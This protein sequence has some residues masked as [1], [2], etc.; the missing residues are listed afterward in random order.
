MTRR[1]R[2]VILGALG[3]VGG[4]LCRAFAEEY[5][6]VAVDARRRRDRRVIRGDMRRLRDAERV[7]DGAD[8]VVDLVTAPWQGPFETVH[9]NNIPATW[10]AFEAARRHGVARVVYASSNHVTG[11][12]ERDAPYCRIVAGDYEGL[13]PADF[14]KITTSMPIR[15]DSPY[16]VGKAFG[17]AT[18]RFYADAH[19]VPAMCLRI[20]SLNAADRP[21]SARH[22]A[23]LLTHADLTR[24]V[25]CC[26]EAP[27]S[28]DFATF[29]GVSANRWRI[30]DIDDA[31]DLIGYEPHDDAESWRSDQDS[32]PGVPERP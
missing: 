9:R 10:N 17:E 15:P 27:R 2:V 5:D 19:G 30:W 20:G 25:R 29:Y 28:I 32:T 16:G 18:A 24:L 26:I 8:V 7:I 21:S 3:L 6:V 14:R 11:L 23:S 22:F 12:Y 13:D 1:R 31:R 4:V